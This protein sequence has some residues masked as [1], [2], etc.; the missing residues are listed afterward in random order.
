[1]STTDQQTMGLTRRIRSRLRRILERLLPG[2]FAPRPDFESVSRLARAVHCDLQYVMDIS[3]ES[4]WHTRDFV[5]S[6]GGFS[7]PGEQRTLSRI[8]AGDRTRSDMLLL[9]L[10]EVSVRRIPGSMAELGVHRGESARLIHHYCP[11]RMLYL[12][13]TFSGFVSGD[14]DKEQMRVR[15]NEKQQFADTDV[16]IAMATV[17]P[18]NSNVVPIVGWFP[19]SVN[20]EVAAATFAFVN[21]DADLQAPTAAGLEFFWPRL[22]PGGFIVVH[23]YNSWPGA[24]MAVDQFLAGNRAAAVPMPDKSGSVVLVKV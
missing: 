12:F 19:D 9:L 23:D 13:D 14:L 20:P 6:F 15:Y 18:V 10:R 5:A 22:S 16:G 8:H 1:V 4:P 21:L 3:P 7:P 11:E 17:A 24:R 2:L